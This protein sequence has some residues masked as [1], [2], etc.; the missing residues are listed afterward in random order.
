MP[1]ILMRS[2]TPKRAKILDR[3]IVRREM[4]KEGVQDAKRQSLKMA[5]ATVKTWKDKPTFKTQFFVKTDSIGV[6]IYPSPYN[7]PGQRWIW[8]NEGTNPR[9]IVPKKRGGRLVFRSKYM[10][11]TRTGILGS[12]RGKSSGGLIFAKGLRRW[13]RG[14][15]QDLKDEW[16]T[17]WLAP[18]ELRRLDV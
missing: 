1:R 5:E 6:N 9:V 10:P 12:R 8:I 15:D 7:P 16:I 13:L 17:L 2:I 4:E 14:S 3:K 11:K 18:L